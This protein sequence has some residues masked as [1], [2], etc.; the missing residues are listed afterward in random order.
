MINLCMSKKV[1]RSKVLI[2]SS[3][4]PFLQATFGE[5][6][7]QG[8]QVGIEAQEFMEG[9]QRDSVKNELY[10]FIIKNRDIFN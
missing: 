3:K 10:N 2:W 5:I 8:T 1:Y 4:K 6:L 9:M 7:N